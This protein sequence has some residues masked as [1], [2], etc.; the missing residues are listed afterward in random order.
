MSGQ[1]S[2]KITNSNCPLVALIQAMLKR[3]LVQSVVQ[4]SLMTKATNTHE[5][6]LFRVYFFPR[7][8]AL[9]GFFF[10]VYTNLKKL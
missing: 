6:N 5:N 8:Q 7:K 9:R 4:R 1:K 3:E 10:R 2:L